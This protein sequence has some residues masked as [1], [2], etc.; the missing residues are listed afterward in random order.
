MAFRRSWVRLPS[1]P[2][3][4]TTRQKACGCCCPCRLFRF[5]SPSK[6]TLHELTHWRQ[7]AADYIVSAGILVATLAG[8]L[9]AEPTPVVRLNPGFGE[10]SLKLTLICQVKEFSDQYLVQHEI[11][12]RILSRFRRENIPFPVPVQTVRVTRNDSE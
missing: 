4:L 5:S 9:V 8:G 12:K 11:R 10:Y 2:R 1:A 3:E 6:D 7:A